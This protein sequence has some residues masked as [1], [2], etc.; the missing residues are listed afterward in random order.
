MLHLQQMNRGEV[1][2]QKVANINEVF[3]VWCDD[4]K[5]RQTK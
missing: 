3:L 5:M 4:D 2:V 1:G